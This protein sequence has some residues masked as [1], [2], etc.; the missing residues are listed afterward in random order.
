MATL[1][2]TQYIRFTMLDI[3]NPFYFWRVN[4]PQKHSNVP[5]Y[6]VQDCTYISARSNLLSD[7]SN[8][9]SSSQKISHRGKVFCWYW[10]N[11][12]HTKPPSPTAHTEINR[13]THIYQSILTSPQNFRSLCYA[14]NEWFLFQKL[15]I[16]SSHI[17]PDWITCDSHLP[18][19][20][21]ECC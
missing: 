2:A 8:K 9:V 10:F 3:T 6:Y 1:E 5:K 18:G 16:S 7:L 4:L 21:K 13:P 12:N 11:I 20:H 19:K 17:S 14:Q 15:L